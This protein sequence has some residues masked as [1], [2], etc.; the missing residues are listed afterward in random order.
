MK[1]EELF[2]CI[3]QAQLGDRQAMQRIIESFLPL[4]RK[5]ARNLPSTVSKD[6]EQTIIEKIVRAVHDYDLQSIPS[7][8]DFCQHME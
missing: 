8:T 4:I 3:Q 6:F 5:V 7:F 1:N 2:H